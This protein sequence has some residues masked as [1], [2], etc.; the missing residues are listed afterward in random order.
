MPEPD[1]KNNN[2]KKIACSVVFPVY[3]EEES[4]PPLFS[5]VLTVMSGLQLNYEMIFVDDCS[6]DESPQ[7]LSQFQKDLPEIVQI[8]PLAERSGQTKALRAGLDASRGERIVTLDADLQNDPADIPALLNKLDEG[9]DCVCGWRKD[10]QDTLLK[11][12][13]S[14]L[15]NILQRLFTRMTIHDVSCTLRVYRRECID[16]VPLNWEGQ[17]RFIP[18]SLAL[19]GYKVGE[20]TSHHRS[21]QY[22][23]TKYSHRRIFRV[24]GDFFKI[25]K[26]GGKA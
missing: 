19:Q 21:R 26:A 4:L 17:H 13:L 2:S 5:E 14:K 1:S 10:R 25:L 23:T 15:G 18:L 8:V 7:L 20:I 6:S 22:G 12:A 16:H 24:I 9:F 3:N 11:A